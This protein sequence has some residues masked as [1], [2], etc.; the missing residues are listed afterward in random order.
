MVTPELRR[1]YRRRGIGLIPPAEGVRSLMEELALGP[2]G[3]AN[4]VIM[5][6]TGLE[7]R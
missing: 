2:V 7:R 6:G 5:S 3:E 4:V 1:E